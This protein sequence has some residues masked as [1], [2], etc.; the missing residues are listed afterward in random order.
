MVGSAAGALSPLA[1]SDSAVVLT[2]LRQ[3]S[4]DSGGSAALPITGVHRVL[5]VHL[6]PTPPTSSDTAV[7]RCRQVPSH[8]P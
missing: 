3:R 7:Q 6:P 2:N 4:G 1:T 5:K 8:V